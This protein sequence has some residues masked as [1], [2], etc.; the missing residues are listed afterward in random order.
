LSYRKVVLDGNSMTTE[1]ADDAVLGQYLGSFSEME[2]L[3]FNLGLALTHPNYYVSYG[4]QNVNGGKISSGDVFMERL[5]MV[6]VFQAGYR[7]RLDD[8]LGVAT[9]FMYRN[10]SDLPANLE[11]N[12]KVILR[13]RL[14]LGAGHRIDYANNFQFGIL[15][16]RMR[17]GYVYEMPMMKSYLLPN[18]THEFMLS[19][20]LFGDRRGMIW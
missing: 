16:D 14:W 15:F 18:V 19:Y 1:Q 4:V 10:Q 9:N 12:F 6:G 3:D 13:D 2:V 5:E 20:A 11:L 8:N 7:S 17:I